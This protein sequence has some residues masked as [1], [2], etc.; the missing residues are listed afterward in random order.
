[1][2]RLLLSALLAGTSMALADLNVGVIVSAT[3]PAASLGIPERNTVAL[4]PQTL[5]GQKVNYIILDDASDTTTA[6]TN[7]RKLIQENKVDIIIGTTTTPASLAMID[8]VAEAKVPMI[9]LAASESIIAP[10]DPKRFW[11]FKTPQTDALMAAAIAQHMAA[12]NV[13]TIGYI[14][15]N[16]AYGEGWLKEIQKYAQQRGIRVVAT[17]KFNRTDTSVTGQVLK[18]VSARPD[19]VLVGAS[20]VPGVVPQ[21]AL[22]DRGFT[23][24]IYQ[25]HGVANPDFLRVG[26]R[27]VE[28]AILPAGPIL[29]ASQLPDANPNKKAS[30]NY[31]KLYEDKYG[32]GTINT[33]GGHMW[34]AGLLLQ[35]AV[36]SA[37]KVA[38]PGTA[39]FRAALR[40]SLENTRNVIGTHGIFNMGK[41]DHLGLNA[42]ARVMVTIENGTWKLLK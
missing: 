39:E 33:F 22:K 5:S 24:Q 26:G 12:N 7:A 17:E 13:K 9:S 2:K 18:I 36:P 3:G 31:I 34:D 10:V 40:D 15:F 38:R 6:V 42:R 23:G 16:D 28:G 21:K 8:V 32:A 29:V 37:L 27:D 19:A 20:G 11:V 30:L 41:D 14:G 25:T 1:M 4:L 35:K